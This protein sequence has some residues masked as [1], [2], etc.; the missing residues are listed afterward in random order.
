LRGAVFK[1]IHMSEQAKRKT[2]L[3]TLPPEERSRI[4]AM[5][6]RTNKGRKPWNFESGSG[7]T[8]RRGY[9]WV[10]ITRNGQR[11]AIREHRLVMEQY[12]G[13]VIE[14][15]ELVHHINGD[16]LDNRVENL[17]VMEFGKHTTEHCSG[18]RHRE[19]SK[20][21]MQLFAQMR[22]ELT[23]TRDINADL[24]EA[25]K[26]AYAAIGAVGLK[27]SPEAPVWQEPLMEAFAGLRAALTKAGVSL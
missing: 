17:A 26:A 6:G 3:A 15:W 7:W 24:A 12:L 13:R 8:D 25:C 4:C 2:G 21:S 18:R 20:R 22:E 10:Y 9:R 14:P 23:R 5:G 19:D 11:T 27:L 1:E 16:K